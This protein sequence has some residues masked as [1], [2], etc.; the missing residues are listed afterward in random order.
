[1][2]MRCL[3]VPTGAGLDASHRLDAACKLGR[4]LHAHVSVLFVKPPSQALLASLPEVAIAAGVNLDSLEREIAEASSA[5]KAAL[6]AWCRDHDVGLATSSERLD[7]T[8]AS[9]REETGELE[10]IVAL[11]GRVNDLILV[12]R[13]DAAE[14]FTERVFDTAV[15]EAGRPVLM[16]PETLPFDLLSHVAIA[17]N[18]TLEAARVIGQSIAL[19]HEADRV[20]VIEAGHDERDG[21]GLADLTS[22]LRWHGIVTEALSVLPPPGQSVGEAI[23]AEVERLEASM[24]VMGAYTHSRIRQFL[25]GGVTRDVVTK[26]KVP[27]LMTH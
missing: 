6:E 23:L 10:T 17:W 3:L 5:G 7:T 8:F 22:Y 4:R 26:A 19:L 18:G 9:W 20:T 2:F 14:P 21:A 27:V 11:I 16:V 25:L 15:F 1:M 13:P 24:L 12:D